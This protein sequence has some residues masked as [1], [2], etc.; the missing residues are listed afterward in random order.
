MKKFVISLHGYF[1]LT[2]YHKHR[3]AD[4]LPKYERSNPMKINRFIALA[5]IALL[6]VAG[7]GAVVTRS[8]ATANSAATAQTQPYD[9]QR[10]GSAE[11]AQ[12]TDTDNVE[13]GE[14]VE[15]GQPDGL[16]G[17]EPPEAEDSSAT[18]SGPQE[19]SYASSLTVDQAST[20]DMSEADEASALQGKAAISA[21]EAEASALN[22][23]P[24][25]TVVKTELDNENGAL[26]YSVE[27]S[28]GADVKVDAG[29]GNILYTDSGGD[30]EG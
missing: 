8:L 22:A 13:Y 3:T 29:N 17:A 15:D 21:A 24:G 5:A 20:Q 10:D 1:I 26:V 11:G 12:P 7:M 25:T 14:Q 9:Q 27:L 19:P 23:N 6:V 18:D 4:E 30:N 2:R 16:E 28:N